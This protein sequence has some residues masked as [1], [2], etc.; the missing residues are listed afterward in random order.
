M[1]T[2]NNNIYV[3]G[4]YDGCSKVHSSAE[5][6]IAKKDVWIA[7]PDMPIGECNVFLFH[8]YMV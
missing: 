1:A 8:L 2:L 7:L 4:G 3:C 5:R 6:Y